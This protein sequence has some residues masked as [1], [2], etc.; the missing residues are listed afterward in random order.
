MENG[1]H[2]CF[3]IEHT[4]INKRIVASEFICYCLGLSMGRYRLDKE[5]LQIAHPDPSEKELTNYQYN[6]YSVDID[7]DAIIPLLGDDGNFPDDA[8]LRTKQ[9]IFQS[10][11]KKTILRISAICKN[12]YE[13][14]YINGLVNFFGL[15]ML[16]K[17]KQLIKKTNLLALL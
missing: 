15:I 12:F 1:L 11:V 7:D 6:G 10:G 17:Q 14:L 13:C 8:L 9:I 4:F 3:A 5:G 2:K 16:V